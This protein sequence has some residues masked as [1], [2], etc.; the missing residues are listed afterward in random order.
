MLDPSRQ[1]AELY[2]RVVQDE[3]G[4]EATIEDDGDVLFEHPE[5]GG[6]SSLSRSP[7]TLDT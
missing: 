5:L 1:L 7:L 4:L 2:Q 6:F 3:L